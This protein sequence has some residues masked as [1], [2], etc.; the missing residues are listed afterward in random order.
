MNMS[1]VLDYALVNRRRVG[2]R[3]ARRA[4]KIAALLSTTILATG[5]S[6]LDRLRLLGDTP[7]LSA[8]NNPTAA[9]GY[10]P[11]Q[12]PMPAPQPAIYQP[13]SLWRTGSRAF[14]KARTPD[15][16][17]SDRDYQYQRSGQLAK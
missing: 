5:C 1:Q 4:A 15:R 9:P 7:P 12:M 10:K 8:I 3:H 11:V 17:H 13:N 2:A 6:S 14:F 16:R